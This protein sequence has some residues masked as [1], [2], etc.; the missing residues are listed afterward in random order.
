MGRQINVYLN[1]SGQIQDLVGN[2]LLAARITTSHTG[3]TSNTTPPTITG[4]SP[5]NGDAGISTNAQVMIQFSTP[6]NEISAINGVQVTQNGAGVAGAFSFQNN[7]T[8]LIFTP[9]NPYLVAPVTVA[10]TPGVTDNA[11]NVIAN[12]VSFTFTVDT[13]ALTTRPYVSMANPPNNIVGVGRNITLQA[14]FNTR[15]N[16]LT[17]TPTSFVVVDDNSNPVL[18]IPGTITVSPDRRT[19]SFVPSTPYAAN[20][21]Y[22][23]YL[24]SSYSTTSITDLYGNILNGFAWCFTTGAATDTTPPV[25]TQVTPP[26]GAQGVPL[27]T[28]VSVQVSKP[29]SQFAFPTEAGGVVLPLTVGADTTGGPIVPDDLGFFPG[30]TSITIV[31]GGNGDL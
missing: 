11:G 16:Q 6:I 19:A 14:Q 13:P 30:G 2:K 17:V 8:Q 25:V 5:Q 3:F 20:E 22:C 26:D 31:A 15:I 29:L 23:W 24:D 4:Y 12:T 7:D 27:N 1:Q 21:R 10:T 9:T 18:F 28:L